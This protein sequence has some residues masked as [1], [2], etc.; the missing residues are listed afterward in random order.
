MKSRVWGSFTNHGLL[1][2]MLPI[3]NRNYCLPE[4]NMRKPRFKQVLGA[5]KGAKWLEM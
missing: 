4:K 3:K 1:V 2:P 5:G